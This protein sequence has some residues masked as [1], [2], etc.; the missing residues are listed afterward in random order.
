MA[1]RHPQAATNLPQENG[2]AIP[3]MQQQNGARGLLSRSSPEASNML[4]QSDNYLVTPFLPQINVPRYIDYQDKGVR[5][6]MNNRVSNTAK[7]WQARGKVEDE[8]TKLASDALSYSMKEWQ[9]LLE[10]LTHTQVNPRVQINY[11]ELE[12]SAARWLNPASKDKERLLELYG[13]SLLCYTL[14][15]VSGRCNALSL[16]DIQRNMGFAYAQI[17]ALLGLSTTYKLLREA[18][19]CYK[20][21]LLT[22]RVN[23]PPLAL[24]VT[25]QNIGN[26]YV[27]LSQVAPQKE[28][29]QYFKLAQ[30]SYQNALQIASEE[31]RMQLQEPIAY[32]KQQLTARGAR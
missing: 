7:T 9:F 12:I 18:V 29:V 25:L 2:A 21:A 30:D 1:M 6:E 16:A 17:G 31:Q 22:Y 13:G 3:T 23:P 8:L 11:Q 24:F 28:R 27:A 26:A 5:R 19:V 4:S 15:K 10:T 20:E 32:V 14:L